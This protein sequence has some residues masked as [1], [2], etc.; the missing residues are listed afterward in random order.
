MPGFGLCTCPALLAVGSFRPGAFGAERGRHRV[1]PHRDRAGA[2]HDAAGARAVL[3]RAGAREERA[4]GADAVLRDRCVVS[5]LWLVV[6]Y[7]LAFDGG[8][9]RAS[10]GSA[11]RSS[12]AST[13]R[14]SRARFPRVVFAMF[15]MTFAIITPA[16]II[17]AFAER[18]RFR[19]CCCSARCGCS[20]L[21]PVAH[22]VW[23][24]G[25][26]ASAGRRWTSPA[27][28]V[29]HLER[30]RRGAGLRAGARPARAAFPHEPM[31]P[32]SLGDDHAGAAMLWVGWFG[33]NA[34][35]ALAADGTAGMAMLVTHIRAAA[36]AL[37]WLA[38][39]WLQVRQAERARHRD[40]HG[41]GPRHD[42]AG[43]G[44][45]RADRRAGH[46]PR[47]GVVC[48]FARPL[49]K[50]AL[51]IDDSL[52]VF[53]VHGVGGMLGTLLTASLADRALRRARLSRSR[54]ARAPS[55]ACRCSASSP[56]ACGRSR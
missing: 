32:H 50:R 38:I 25:W 8:D 4:V 29:V 39:E 49:I 19:R 23:G 51:S 30:G 33:F 45:R 52:D 22:W 54:A 6:G 44:L 11:R 28:L 31:P 36:G 3:R 2:V 24:G 13:S 17:G 35:S 10:A 27:A 41:R 12:A 5:L 37:A 46:R 20:R 34:G 26:L 15:Q 56:S 16:L 42:H 14:R 40:R 9:A 48:F 7:S 47:A 1:D 21:L 53:A 55:S 43:L 18:I